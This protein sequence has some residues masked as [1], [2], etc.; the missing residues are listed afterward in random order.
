MS[1]KLLPI[2]LEIVG[3]AAIG[4]GIGIEMAYPCQHRLGGGNHWK[5]S[6]RYRWR[7]LG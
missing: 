2:S 5:L 7:Y 3:I 6:G 4:V 1:K